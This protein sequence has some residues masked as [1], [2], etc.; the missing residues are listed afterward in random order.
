[1]QK[2]LRVL[3]E[4]AKPRHSNRFQAEVAKLFLLDRKASK[5]GGFVITYK[6]KRNGSG[7]I[8]LVNINIYV[9]RFSG[10]LKRKYWKIWRQVYWSLKQ[11]KNCQMK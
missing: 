9:G 2:Q 5:I 1:M 6:N 4:R 3:E 11:Q 8:S 7:R 10:Y